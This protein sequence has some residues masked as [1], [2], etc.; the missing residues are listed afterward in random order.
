MRPTVVRLVRV[1]PRSALHLGKQKVIPRPKP[2]YEDLNKP[3]TLDILLK[4]KETAGDAWPSNIRIEPVVKKQAFRQV[5][6]KL[7]PYLKK[8]LREA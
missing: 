1:L 8:M 7:R 4:Q 6:P 5:Q 3:T 2:Q